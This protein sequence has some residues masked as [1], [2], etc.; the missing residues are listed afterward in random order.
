MGKIIKKARSE[1][2]N[3]M[4]KAKNDPFRLG[5]H[6]F[7]VDKWARYLLK[8]H[9]EADPEV[10]L[11]GVW[12]HDLGLYVEPYEE[13]H[14]VGSEKTAK[15][16]LEKNGYSQEK[17]NKVLHVIRAHRCKDVL[18]ETIEAKIVACADSASHFTDGVYIRLIMS[19]EKRQEDK[20]KVLQKIDR[21]YRDLALFP[22]VK[23]KLTPLYLSWKNLLEN[24]LK[25]NY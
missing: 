2:L 12:L 24:Y 25:V 8:I 15:I 11:L 3:S 14:A 9:K 6:V 23:K 7:E 1:F 21:D 5:Y 13:D 19:W 20:T 4:K 10:V 18:P 22:D 16:F 17:I